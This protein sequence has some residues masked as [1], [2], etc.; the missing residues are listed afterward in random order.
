MNKSTRSLIL[1][2]AL[3][4]FA[5]AAF[6]LD[7]NKSISVEDGA[8][9][10]GKSTVNGS[11]SIGNGAIVDGSLTTVNGRIRIED[12]V[13]LEDAETVNGGIVVGS[14]VIADDI[15]SVNGA[16]SLD[17]N[18]TV[19]GDLSVVNGKISVGRGS[20]IADDVSNVN[21]EIS[22][23]G[24]AIGGDLTTVNGDISLLDGSTVAGD[25][26]VEMPKGWG[27]N[28]DRRKPTV[29]IGPGSGVNGAIILEREVELFISNTA[30]VGTVRGAMS[31][32]EAVRYNGDTP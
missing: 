10:D 13:Q 22:L 25:L 8:R 20:R 11:I 4:P 30:K 17:Q 14:G 6:G 9:T 26:K 2:T 31:L 19:N 15:N 32:D 27:W 3:L 29:I 12:N 5:T 21:G 18:V 7:I 16:I 1:A 24:A 28:F 23:H